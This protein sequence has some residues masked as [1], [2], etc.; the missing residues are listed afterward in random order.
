MDQFGIANTE[1]IISSSH[2]ISDTPD[3]NVGLIVNSND[4]EID[5]NRDKQQTQLDN[6]SEQHLNE[7]SSSND[8][9]MKNKSNETGQ[10]QQNY[11]IIRSI[12]NLTHEVN[13]LQNIF[14]TDA[15][16]FDAFKG[17][18][19]KCRKKHRRRDKK[20]HLT[21]RL[22]KY[23]ENCRRR[24]NSKANEII[25]PYGTKPKKVSFETN[26]NNSWR[27]I[28]DTS[29]TNTLGSYSSQLNQVEHPENE[30]S[31]GNCSF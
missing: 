13:A 10:Y 22:K 19:R 6:Y 3:R 26:Q 16:L 25:R 30:S 27:F 14:S 5:I 18:R 17:K 29:N 1:P 15:D 4:V 28:Y 23:D 31:E 20:S 24:S 11:A 7:K 21:K 12:V 2:S 9:N 8:K